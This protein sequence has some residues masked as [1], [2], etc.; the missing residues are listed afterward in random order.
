MSRSTEEEVRTQMCG[1][2]SPRQVHTRA[3]PFR[4]NQILR[5]R[6]DHMWTDQNGK[7]WDRWPRKPA[8]ETD[9]R[10]E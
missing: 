8:P 4:C 9:R 1:S 5:H 3:L 10:T 2:Q 7:V 6:G